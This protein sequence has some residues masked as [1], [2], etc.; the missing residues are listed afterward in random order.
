M[1][2]E[3]AEDSGIDYRKKLDITKHR[4]DLSKGIT[5]KNFRALLNTYLIHD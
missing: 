1:I 3:Y 5:N 4:Y 2:L